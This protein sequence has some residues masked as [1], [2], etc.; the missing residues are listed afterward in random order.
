[1]AVEKYCVRQFDSH[2]NRNN[3]TSQRNTSVKDEGAV[4][5]DEMAQHWISFDD[6]KHE[7]VSH[8]CGHATNDA[9][10]LHRIKLANHHPRNDE[11]AER[12]SDDEDEYASDRNPGVHQRNPLRYPNRFVVH[13]GA[14]TEHRHTAADARNETQRS[15]ATPSHRNAGHDGEH[16]TQNAEDNRE[17]ILIHCGAGVFEDLDS[18]EGDRV[19]ARELVHHEVDAE[20]AEGLQTRWSQQR[21]QDFFRR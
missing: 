3:L 18:V 19:N 20:N 14:E 2:D 10:D 13:V 11:E 16:E 15:S 1:M 4:L 17:S 8:A 9:S 6:N 7:A 12:A 21:L 5:L